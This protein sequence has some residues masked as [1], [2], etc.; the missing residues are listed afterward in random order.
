MIGTD[1]DAFGPRSAVRPADDARPFG[2]TPR[3]RGWPDDDAGEIP[4]RPPALLSASE[5]DALAAVQRDRLHLHERVIRCRYRFV[6]LANP[7]AAGRRDERP[8]QVT[9]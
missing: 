2:R 6:D 1:S 8:H 3:I 5:R 7:D 4:S 9:I